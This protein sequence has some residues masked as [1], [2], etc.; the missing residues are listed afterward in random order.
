MVTSWESFEAEN[1]ED[2]KGVIR[3]YKLKKDKRTN[4]YLENTTRKTK[5]FSLACQFF[6]FFFTKDGNLYFFS[7]S[8]FYVIVCP[9]VF[10]QLI[11]SDYSFGIFKVFIFK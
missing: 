10:L 11:V 6:L 2:T 4:Y 8:V 5:D 1:F 3:N 9:F 7:D